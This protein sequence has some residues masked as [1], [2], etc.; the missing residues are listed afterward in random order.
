MVEIEPG[1]S[2]STKIL[3]RCSECNKTFQWLAGLRKHQYRHHI[4]EKASLEC[5]VCQKKLTSSSALTRHARTH[6]GEKTHECSVCLK[7]FTRCSSLTTHARIHS[8]ENLYE[9]S[10]CLKKL[11]SSN[12]LKK[13]ARTHTGEKPYECAVCLKRFSVLSTL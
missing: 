3:H 8:G 5:P 10:V 1:H 11:T 9:C 2:S 13:H 6:T 7:K 12:Q 4:K